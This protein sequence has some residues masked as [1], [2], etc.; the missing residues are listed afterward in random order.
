MTVFTVGAE[1]VALHC[2]DVAASLC[3]VNMLTT[4]IGI[5][6]GL[7]AAVD[8]ASM[9]F[10]EM[11]IIRGKSVA[12]RYHADWSVILAVSCTRSPTLTAVSSCA[13]ICHL[14]VELLLGEV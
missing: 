14:S 9:V 2:K 5:T 3:A 7:V 1:R 4:P 8:F 13:F 11:T 10:T 12:G 6:S